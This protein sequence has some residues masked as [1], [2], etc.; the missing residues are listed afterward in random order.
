MRLEAGFALTATSIINSNRDPRTAPVKMAEFMPH[1]D[2]KEE[3]ELS[4]DNVFNKL[5]EITGG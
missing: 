2:K 4:P 5:M 1:I 3:I